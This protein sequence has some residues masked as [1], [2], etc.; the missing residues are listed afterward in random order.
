M[1]RK[2]YLS[3]SILAVSLA[4]SWS[5]A[6]EPVDFGREIR[7]ILAGNCFI[8]HGP[9]QAQRKAGLRLDT[10][11]G[12]T[13]ER[14][15]RR[16]VVPGDPSKSEL[17]R[18]ISAEDDDRMPPAKSGKQLTPEQ[19]ALLKRWV[20]EGAPYA[21]HWAYSKPVRPAL[22]A[23]RDA[24]WPRNA[25]DRFVL[26]RLEREGLGPSPEADRYALIRRVSLDLTGL[27]PS[28]EEAEAFAADPA[29]EAYERLVDRILARPAY[30][31]H[32]A[33]MWLDLARYADSAG[34]AD[35]PPRT[36]WAYREY[37]IDSF[38]V[39][40]PFDRFTL[41]QI[42]GDLL[43]EPGEEK[44]VATAFHRNTQTNNEGGTNDEE[45]RNV[46][47]VDRV[48]TTMAVWMGTT[49]ACAQCHNHKYDPIS[50][51][52]YFRFFAFFNNTEDAD[53]TDESP[54]LALYSDAQ[55]LRRKELEGEI[56]RLEAT[57]RATT[58]ELTVSERRWEERLAPDLAW[59]TL[60]PEAFESRGGAAWKR[61]EDGS[62]TVERGQKTDVYRLELPLAEDKPAALRLEA[63]PDPSLPGGG[64]GHAGGNFVITRLSA[65]LIPPQADRLSGRYLRVELPG[66]D[67]ILSL[68]EVQVFS[69][70]ENLATRGEARQSST[71]FEGPAKLA[72]DGN[73]DGRFGEAR[74]TTHT[75][76]SV[77]PWW[78]VDL[79]AEAPIDQVVLWNRTDQGLH[80][81]LSGF[82][83][84]VLDGKRHAVWERQV[85]EPPNPSTAFS[86]TGVREIALA[87]AYADYSQQG[88]EPEGALGKKGSQGWA[89]GGQTGKPHSLTVIT[90]APIEAPAG[91]RL[92]LTIEQLSKNENHTLGR[93]R[94]SS[95]A[96]PRAAELA[97]V[98]ERIL[99]LAR[100]APD[101]R[102]EAE[103]G[104]VTRFYL[105]N[106]APELEG[107]R[108]RLE[109]ARK[110]LRE[111]KPFTTV[112]VAHELPAG[113]RRKTL[114][115]RRG[116][117]LDVDREVTEGLP[118]AFPALPEGAPRDRLALARWLIDSRNPLTGRVIANRYWEK[119]FG[120]GIVA[121]SEEFGTQGEL[122]SHPELLD[123]LAVELSEGGWELKGFLRTLVTS[124]TYRQSSR[125][126]PAGLER[127][128]EDRLLS[129]GPR[130]RLTA[131]EVRDQALAVSGLLSPKMHGPP[132]RPP[133]PSLGLSAAFGGGIDWQTSEG[134]DRYRRGLYTTWRRSSPYPSMTTF[135]APNREVCTVRRA[136]TN[137]PLQ[138]L[139][140]LNDP[141]Y[142]EAAQALARRMTRA[143]GA[144]ADRARH[145]LRLVLARPPSEE[146]I[147]RLV[148]LYE[149]VR[150]KLSAEKEKAMK[151][152]TVPIGALTGGEDP[153]EVA[154]WTVV[155]NVL[156][157]LDETLMKR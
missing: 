67:K 30:G 157:N 38:N 80:T 145:G 66:N 14:K 55:K 54:V 53:R 85:A 62:V 123:W 83:L 154:A 137:T 94:V 3:G 142:V 17:V 129:R 18:R 111:L 15:G 13:A 132:V 39:D 141:V 44:I 52:E 88:F 155:G 6:A 149:E 37:V 11:E 103:R 125:V 128:P 10:R 65:R 121:T 63:L 99:S 59:R 78:E 134:E 133:Q 45:Y 75:A 96:D 9:D 100:T 113:K 95:S 7:S 35:D 90:A 84:A 40:K 130:L 69:G 92:G 71:D 27:P 64:P 136:R 82:R 151:L 140:T 89:V 25:I 74:S 20:A 105:E 47:V 50:Q 12:A 79:K 104:E 58:P 86:P 153:V 131:E 107:E 126:T 48:N 26:A 57:L 51:E 108:R 22:P 56:A 24:A 102:S 42:A 19:V 93:L 152:A 147:S 138:A 139:V 21:Q 1:A 77:N 23:V 119:L 97:R 16:P 29:P 33:R 150:V 91:S 127:D 114:I 34:Y 28:L 122:P 36:I 68:A 46:A 49:I 143:G 72:V 70:G 106:V 156:L 117:F 60:A 32:W 118:S 87:T 61:L 31:E 116:N 98:P 76:I 81:R 148:R 120:T 8:C 146:E 101:K 4:G 5:G 73:T 110:E 115:Q 144:P 135:D 2:L 43:P 109:A 41:E 124:A 112:P